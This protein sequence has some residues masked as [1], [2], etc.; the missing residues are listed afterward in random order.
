MSSSSQLRKLTLLVFLCFG[1]FM[2]Y[3]DA[4]IV[5]V[6]LPEMQEGL[7]ADISELQWIIDSYTLAFAC[8]L[9]TA[10]TVGDIVGR[11]KLFLVGLI[12]FTVTSALCALAGSVEMLLIARALQGAF[13]A[14]VIPTSLSLV[15]SAYEDAAARARAIGVW[16]GL[17]GLALS[18]GPV[19]G[20]VLV[21]NLGWQSIFWVNVPIG[22]IAAAVLPRL[23]DEYRSSEA[24]NV[25]PVGQALF[26]LAVAA[27]AYGLIE[28]NNRGWS[29]AVI[30][31]SFVVSG[32]ALLVFVP[33]E[34]RRERP[35]LPLRL[36]RQPIVVVAGTVNFLGL[37]GLFAAIFLLT[38]YLQSVEGL[39]ATQTGVRFL[40]LTVPIMVA[41]FVAS[42]LAAR[43]G[44]RWPIVLGSVCSAAGL[45]GLVLLDPGDGFAAYWWALALLGAG[46]SLTGA[47]ATVSLLETVGAAQVGMAAGVSN[48]FRQVGAVF[49]VALSG[50]LL[51]RELD[52]GL[53]GALARLRSASPELRALGEE[54]LGGGDISRLAELPPEARLAVRDAIRPV[55]LD[56]LHDTAVVAAAG[57]L[58]GGLLTLLILRS[59]TR[60]GRVVAAADA[61]V[62]EVH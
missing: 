26:V 12:G 50:A 17:G 61:P 10:G 44:P 55:F 57:S 40:A 52:D 23:L 45:Y 27:L 5:N 42:V 54:S 13:G 34:L 56:G 18:V 16:A 36:F 15:S 48:T 11:K 19:L 4:T 43:V 58:V 2:V 25:D 41:S 46:V 32:L 21:E 47:P 31:G 59:R 24:G 49:G 14:V 3:L 1:V 51:Q 22:V 9:L 60:S 33:W 29:S 35:M 39:S 38:L 62:T 30:V 6:A 7:S 53:P 20:G 8:L 28:G 37:F